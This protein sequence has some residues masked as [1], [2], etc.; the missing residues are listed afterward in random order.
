MVGTEKSQDNF[1]KETYVMWINL[2][3]GLTDKEIEELNQLD[4]RK[5]RFKYKMA[6]TEKSDE[7]FE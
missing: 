2:M 5:L 1:S 6:L 4:E 7:M 3:L